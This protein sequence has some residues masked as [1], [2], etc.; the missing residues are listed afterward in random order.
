M[1]LGMIGTLLIGLGRDLNLFSQQLPALYIWS[2]GAF[3]GTFFNPIINGSNQAIW[4]AKVP[5]DVQGRVFA[6]R[7]LIAQIS[8]PLSML[9][10]GPLADAFFEPGMMPDGGLAPIFGGLV[11]TG[12]GAGM[13][14]MFVIAGVLGMLVG[15]AGY[16][17]RSVRHVEDLLL[18]H[19][20]E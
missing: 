8:V 17:F 7:A 19:T 10:S 2:L 14:L 16:A 12:P 9:L 4:Q 18:D 6:T 15:L 3:I 11:G 13:S 1:T 20:Q 5:P